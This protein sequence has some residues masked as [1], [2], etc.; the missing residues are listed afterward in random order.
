MADIDLEAM[1]QNVENEVKARTDSYGRR[2]R[3][4]PTQKRKKKASV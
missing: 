4:C 2:H 1:L 3:K